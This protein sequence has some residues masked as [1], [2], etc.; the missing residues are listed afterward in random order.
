MPRDKLMANQFLAQGNGS[1]DAHKFNNEQRKSLNF[2]NGLASG[3]RTAD[4][5]IKWC[6]NQAG[7]LFY[8]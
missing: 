7:R 2:K 5:F 1:A 4:L 8:V 3:N 6:M